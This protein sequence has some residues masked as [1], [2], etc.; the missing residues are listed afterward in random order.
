[1]TI[2]LA[3]VVGYLIS[4]QNVEL[5]GKESINMLFI[6]PLVKRSGMDYVCVTTNA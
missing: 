4:Y 2:A 5:F 1:M 3:A 6:P